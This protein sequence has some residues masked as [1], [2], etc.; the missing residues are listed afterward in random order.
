MQMLQKM[1]H[2]TMHLLHYLWRVAHQMQMLVCKGAFA[3]YAARSS[4]PQNAT[5]TPCVP[6]S[7]H[8]IFAYGER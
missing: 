6:L 3:F 4:L 2:N 8:Q 5:T 1:W 7:K